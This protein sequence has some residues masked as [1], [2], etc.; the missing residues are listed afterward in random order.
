MSSSLILCVFRSCC[1]RSSSVTRRLPCSAFVKHR[2]TF[3]GDYSI[4]VIAID[5]NYENMVRDFGSDVLKSHKWVWLYFHLRNKSYDEISPYLNSLSFY[6]FE[7][8]TDDLLFDVS[9]FKASKQVWRHQGVSCFQVRLYVDRFR[10]AFLRN[11]SGS[12]WSRCAS[13]PR[14]SWNM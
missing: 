10:S 4:T 11:A 1:T 6:D 2:D 8:E 12:S 5:I 9:K 3:F 13:E 7:L 14:R